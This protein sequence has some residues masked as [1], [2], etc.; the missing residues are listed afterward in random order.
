MYTIR[1]F[2]S[3][4]ELPASY[5]SLIEPNARVDLFSDPEWFAILMRHIFAE[6]GVFRVYGVEEASGGRPLLVVPLLYGTMDRAVSRARVFSSISDPEN[7]AEVAFT[8]DPAVKEPAQVLTALFQYLREGR[9]KH[10]EQPCDVIRLSPMEEGSTLLKTVHAA[11][12][13]AGFWV[14][15]Y[16]N[17]CNHFESTYG[18]DYETYFAGRSA[19]L[20]SNIRRRQRALEKAG[21]LELSMCSD[22]AGMQSAMQDYFTV[23]T[24]SWKHIETM[25]TFDMLDLMQLAAAKGCLRLGFLRLDGEA[26]AAQFWIVTNGVAHCLRLAYREKYKDLSVGVVLTNFMIAHVI[27]KDHVLK[28]DFGYGDD[29]YKGGW[30]KEVRN[31]FGLMAFNPA[32]RIGCYHG[33]RHI[34]GRRLKRAVKHLLRVNRPD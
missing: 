3:F 14:Q 30:M 11:L 6:K 29:D 28:I 22:P 25:I 34:L 4:E 13:A 27:D 15:A 7:Y 21:R 16:A 20:R 10:G 2:T 17:S 33:V 26:A 8:F 24:E 18:I 23:S 31:Y 5:I 12:R 9:P 19:N 32:T 1:H